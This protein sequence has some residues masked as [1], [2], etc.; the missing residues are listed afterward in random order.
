MKYVTIVVPEYNVNPNS[1]GGAFDILNR[2]TDYWQQ[3]G[4]ESRIVIRIA[5]FITELKT[6]DNHFVVHPL[7]IRKIDKTDLVIIP[8]IYGDHGTVINKNHDLI[9]WIK[10]QYD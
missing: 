8:S 2:P 5:G 9:S 10:L 7:D 4:N 3:T 6:H 1:I